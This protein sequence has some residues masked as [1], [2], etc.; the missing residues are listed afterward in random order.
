M[1]IVI[2]FITVFCLTLFS[3]LFGFSQ[4]SAKQ[5]TGA[6]KSAVSTDL[7]WMVA[8]IVV[9]LLLIIAMPKSTIRKTVYRK[10]ENGNTKITTQTIIRGRKVAEG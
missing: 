2:K 6:V 4:D 7:L 5:A 9:L 1:K 3:A 10:D 8:A